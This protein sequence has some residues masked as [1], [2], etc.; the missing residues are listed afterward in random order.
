MGLLPPRSRPVP[1]L[2]LERGRA[3][4]DLRHPTVALLRLR[5]LERQGPYPQ[6]AN[7]RAHQPTGEPWRGRQ[8]VLVVPGLHSDAF[9]DAMEISLSAGRV[10]I[11][12]AGRGESPADP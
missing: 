7:L 10:P 5:L 2:P 9:V 3:G 11:R 4:R 12:T 8:G 1:G 6:G